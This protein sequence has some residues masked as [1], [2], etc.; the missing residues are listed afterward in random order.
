[1]DLLK[2]AQAAFLQL[3]ARA[4]RAAGMQEVKRFVL[5]AAKVIRSPGQARAMIIALGEEMAL[6]EAEIA[7]W[8]SP[9]AL[10]R[11]EGGPFD[12]CDLRHW[13]VIADRA[14]VAAIP[15]RT[16]LTL[17]DDE[18]GVLSGNVGLP[19]TAAVRS[20]KRALLAGATSILKEAGEIADTGRTAPEDAIDA[21]ALRERLAEAMDD[22]PEGWMVRS[23][24][25]GGSNLKSLAGFGIMSEVAPEVRFGTN[26][27]I[28]P[29][30]VRI[31]NRRRVDV[32]DRRTM[33]AAAQGPGETYFLARPWQVA[34]RYLTGEDPHRHGTPFAGKGVWPAEWRAIVVAGRVT[35]VASYYGWAD[36]ASP[37]SARNALAVRDLAQR[38]V[39]EA[40]SL[41]A[42]PR[43]WDI[44]RRR[45]DARFG[46]VEGYMD[47]LNSD[48]GRETVSCTLDFIE[49]NDGP[50][51][52]EGGPSVSPAGGG[53]PC[54]FAGAVSALQGSLPSCEGVAFRAPA[55]VL[56]GDPATWDNE[57][58]DLSDVHWD[59]S[60]VEELAATP[61]MPSNASEGTSKNA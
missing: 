4:E 50:L 51:F 60:R 17:S 40:M 11:G 38:M 55:G 46:D 42:F 61:A 18:Y 13:M 6:H 16:I 15:A 28:G 30:W 41:G 27:E 26:L 19:D 48:W 14:G 10:S 32:S 25:C 9:E 59:W 56:V 47:A 45:R 34:S 2:R 44:E 12:A 29:G 54:A 8:V 33:E 20:L 24:R 37:E 52:L 7:T 3:T 57:F 35:G 5:G 36:Q 39:D 49:T 21:E 58:P 31:G 43:Y 1:M 22:V 23:A 53:H